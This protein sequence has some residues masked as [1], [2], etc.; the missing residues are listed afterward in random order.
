MLCMCCPD[1]FWPETSLVKCLCICCDLCAVLWLGRTVLLTVDSGNCV[2]LW[3]P[4]LGGCKHKPVESLRRLACKCLHCGFGCIV[5]VHTVYMLHFWCQLL[6]C[7]CSCV[8]Q[9]GWVQQHVVLRLQKCRNLHMC[10]KHCSAC[11]QANPGLV[12]C[13]FHGCLINLPRSIPYV[14]FCER[15]CVLV[16][17]LGFAPALLVIMG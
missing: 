1:M 2:V 16:A 15:P 9:K 14:F 13:C 3:Q 6:H 5:H 8:C 12:G 10:F 11:V 7:S 17:A 4:F